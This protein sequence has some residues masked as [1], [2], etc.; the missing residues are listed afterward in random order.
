M[1]FIRYIS[2][3]ILCRIRFLL[4]AVKI[5]FCNPWQYSAKLTFISQNHTLMYWTKIRQRS[6]NYWRA[7][8]NGK[9][10]KMGL[11]GSDDSYGI[12]LGKAPQIVKLEKWK[13]VVFVA[14]GNLTEIRPLLTL[15]QKMEKF[16]NGDHQKWR[17]WGI[18][19]QKWRLWGILFGKVP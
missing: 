11:T 18:L 6:A 9:I 13:C 8:K 12:L 1:R 17:F 4:S 2:C 19:S 5:K 10:S 7:L 3:F 15:P 14:G 16:Q